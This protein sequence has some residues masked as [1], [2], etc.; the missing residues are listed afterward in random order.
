MADKAVILQL[1]YEGRLI[2]F[3]SF[4]KMH[5]QWKRKSMCKE[6]KNCFLL[7]NSKKNHGAFFPMILFHSVKNL[8]GLTFKL[9]EN[10]LTHDPR[11]SLTSSADVVSTKTQF[12]ALWNC[13]THRAN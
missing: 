8:S 1:I 6:G 11:R 13:M 5:F 3:Y 4:L 10:S 2:L 9:P 7:K 12:Q